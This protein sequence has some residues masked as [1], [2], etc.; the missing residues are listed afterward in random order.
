MKPQNNPPDDTLSVLKIKL[1]AVE[2]KL[3][4]TE[5]ECDA[6]RYQRDTLLA[7]IALMS[8]DRRTQKA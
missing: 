2:K 6:L 1:A 3:G 7:T 5:A 8:E 4:P